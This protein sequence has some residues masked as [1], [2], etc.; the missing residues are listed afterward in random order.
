MAKYE[1][2]SIFKQS[3]DLMIELYD[4]IKNFPKEYKYSLWEKLKNYSLDL[5]T[6]IYEINSL[7][8]NEIKI[9]GILK[10]ISLVEK[11]KIL[12]RVS[13]V[14]LTILSK[15]DIIYKWIWKNFFQVLIKMY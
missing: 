10:T 15:N 1:H 9:R 4:E 14:L 2:L 5:V 6:N 3:Y 13:K 7:K 12:M 11:I 8:N